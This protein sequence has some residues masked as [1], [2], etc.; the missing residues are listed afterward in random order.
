M[1]KS[2]N[3]PW[4]NFK[5]INEINNVIIKHIFLEPGHCF[6]LHYHN[7]CDEIWIIL[8]G[9]CTF[10]LN[11]DKEKELNLNDTVFI[12]KGTPHRA[13]NNNPNVVEMLEIQIYGDNDKKEDII[14]IS[15]NYDRI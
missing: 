3:K 14:R 1:L 8:N 7:T 2:F 15:D 11:Q 5:I 12:K 9:S 10:T 6:S 13:Y 4:G